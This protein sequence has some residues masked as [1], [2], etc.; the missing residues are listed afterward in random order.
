LTFIDG[1][2]IGAVPAGDPKIEQNVEVEKA[3]LAALKP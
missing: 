2:V 3:A 1:E